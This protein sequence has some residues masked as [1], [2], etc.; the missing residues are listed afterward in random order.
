MSAVAIGLGWALATICALGWWLGA[1][2]EREAFDL[3][4]EAIAL[5]ERLRRRLVDAE[6]ALLYPAATSPARL[7]TD[8]PSETTGSVVSSESG[9]DS[10]GSVTG[11]DQGQDGAGAKGDAQRVARSSSGETHLAASGPAT[12]LPERF[13]LFGIIRGLML[14][15]NLGDVHDEINHLHDL[16][17]IARPEG[18]F[19]DGWYRHDWIALRDGES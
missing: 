7:P 4:R 15:E 14:S 13:S 11:P 19:L 6:M 18:N 2:L 8:C 3:A 17:G 10:E 5:N 16:V 9:V 1:R 12:D